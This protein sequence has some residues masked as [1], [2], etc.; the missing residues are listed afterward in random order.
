M[1]LPEGKLTSQT[2]LLDIAKIIPEYARISDVDKFIEKLRIFDDLTEI[3][4]D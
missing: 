1:T 3:I 4:D 2:T